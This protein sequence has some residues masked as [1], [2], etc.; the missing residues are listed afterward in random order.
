MRALR[1]VSWGRVG[2]HGT[3][4]E[5]A[6]STRARSGRGV[7]SSGALILGASTPP[8]GVHRQGSG[9]DRSGRAEGLGALYF[10]LKKAAHF[11]PSIGGQDADERNGHQW[12]AG[13]VSGEL[14]G[15][16]RAGVRRDGRRRLRARS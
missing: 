1:I 8:A 13:R 7:R 10:E 6:T 12:L 3:R 2:A 11:E 15:P 4:T 5:G 14:G 16:L 9:V